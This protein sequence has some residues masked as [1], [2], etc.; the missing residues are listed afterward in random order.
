MTLPV[1]LVLALLAQAQTF[2]TLYNFTGGSNGVYPYAGVIQDASGNLY[3]TA[4]GGGD[5]NCFAGY[6]CGVVYKLDTAGT[7]TVLYTFT[8]V[9]DG[10]SPPTP[11]VQDKKGNTYGTTPLGGSSYLGTVFKIDAAGNETVLHSFTGES[12]GC[13]PYQGLVLGKSGTLF[14]TTSSCG[15]FG[16]GTIF[17]VDSA[18]NFTILH[19]FAGFP[20]DGDDPQY[21]HLTM[22]ESGNLYGL[23]EFGGSTGCDDYGCGVLYELSKKGKLTVL[24]NFPGGTS[25]G[26]YPNGSVLRDRAGNLYGTTWACGSYS[27]YGTIWKVGKRGSETVLHNFSGR[28]SDGSR[29]PVG[30]ARDSKGNLYGVTW[31]GGANG[32]GALYKLSASGRFT[33][34]HSFSSSDGAYPWGEVL[35][36]RKGTLFGTTTE[37]G[38][39]GAGTVWKYVP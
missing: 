38:S 7:E 20:S 24:H 19:S 18:G 9:P 39:S 37:G 2:T 23:T 12:D 35:L 3:S 14:G 32:Y 27:Y 33:L 13:N 6:G 25:D 8:G 4:V 31:L 10:E 17:K 11:L 22:D 5:P 16:H 30:V 34:L 15:S 29:P 36:S 26:C 1:V 28:T 21:G